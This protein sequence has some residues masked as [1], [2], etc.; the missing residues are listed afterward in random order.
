[1]MKPPPVPW[2]RPQAHRTAAAD[3]L[4]HLDAREG[5]LCESLFDARNRVRSRRGGAQGANRLVEADQSGRPEES[6]LLPSIEA[7]SS[8]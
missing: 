6:S 3:E 8:W 1:M 2:G 4:A 7:S 5:V